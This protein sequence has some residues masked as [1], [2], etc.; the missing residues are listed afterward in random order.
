MTPSQ[1]CYDLIKSFE[2]CV[3]K[4]YP[5]PGHANGLPITIGWGSTKYRDGSDIKLGDTLTQEG[6]DSLL[7]WEVGIKAKGVTGL[8]N[9]AVITQNAFDA[10]VSFAFNVGLGNLGASTLLKK[11]KAGQDA[12]AEFLRW[13][14][15]GG[16]VMKGLAR[17]RTAEMELYLSA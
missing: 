9:G 15:A 7:A 6:A 16:K 14:K 4:A 5:D 11:V 10:I 2:G 13:N 3:L 1:K 12:S 17:R 8:L